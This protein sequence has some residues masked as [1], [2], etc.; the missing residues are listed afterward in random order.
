[1]VRWDS[2]VGKRL[3]IALKVIYHDHDLYMFSSDKIVPDEAD[4]KLI[5]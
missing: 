5:Q 4:S 2:D 1:M 3:I